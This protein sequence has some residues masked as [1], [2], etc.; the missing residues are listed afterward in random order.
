M[1]CTYR[2][3]A[4]C[5]VWNKKQI[6]C[7]CAY[8][9]NII[10]LFNTYKVLLEKLTDFRLLKKFLA[11]YGH[12]KFITAFTS[13]RYVSLS[14]ASS[15]QSIP[16]HP[17]SWRLILILSSHLHL[18]LPSGLFNSGL[19]TKICLYLSSPPYALRTLPIPLFYYYHPNNIRW[20]LHILK[21]L[22]M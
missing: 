17:H 7:N 12:R 10:L 15:I 22:I 9:I 8:W 11:V 18:C 14:R 5:S 4:R 19:R 21:L 20:G 2:S 16:L 13:A 1:Y 6:L 3:A